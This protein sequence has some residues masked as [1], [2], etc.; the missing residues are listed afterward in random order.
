MEGRLIWKENE[1][2]KTL[3]SDR[4]VVV[5][6]PQ[7]Q[8]PTQSIPKALTKPKR[9]KIRIAVSVDLDAVSGWLGTGM[10]SH[11]FCLHDHR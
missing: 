9:N 6:K 11:Q 5:S 2:V 8:S 1:V 4:L 7:E 10:F 3:S